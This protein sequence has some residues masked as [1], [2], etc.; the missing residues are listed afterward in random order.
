MISLELKQ[1]PHVR[2]W[3]AALLIVSLAL[4]GLH[5]VYAD[6]PVTRSQGIHLNIGDSLAVKSDQSSIQQVF[7]EGNFSAASVTK[8]AHYPANDF[9]IQ[10]LNPGTYE[11]RVMFDYPSDYQVNLFVKSSDTGMFDNRTTYYLSGGAFEL[12]VNATFD[13]P[14]NLPAIVVA[15]VSPWDSFVGWM[16]NF[17]QAFPLWVKA[18]YL[19]LGIQFLGVGGLW[20]RRETK[21]KEATTQRLDWGD[22]AYLWLDVLYKFLAVSFVAIV[23][24]MGGELLILFVLR[25][26]FLATITLLSLWDLFV[27]GFAAGAII[28]VYLIRFTL[29]KAFDLKPVGDE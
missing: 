7:L 6:Q 27:I 1:V 22:R 13:S 4:A 9:E 21:K 17:G 5:P 15:P 11:L 19:V 25:F 10:A 24:I 20:I 12:D 18:L 29:E 16:G 28:I 2:S 26:M 23:A 3:I 8:P 14:S